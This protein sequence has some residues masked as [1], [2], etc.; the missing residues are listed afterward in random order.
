[1]AEVEI[2][3]RT[4]VRATDAEVR[5][6]LLGYISAVV[7]DLLVL[8]GITV[9]KTADGRTVLS[10]PERVDRRG[11]RHSYFR[12]VDG[13]ARCRIEAAIFGELPGFIEESA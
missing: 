4:W 12:P 3:I 2:R 6:G 1:M 11:R 7:D 13:R 10:F 9:R 5:T 8:D